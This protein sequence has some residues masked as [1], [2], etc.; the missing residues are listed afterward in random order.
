MFLKKKSTYKRDGGKK[1]TIEMNFF[2]CNVKRGRNSTL[3]FFLVARFLGLLMVV[4][5]N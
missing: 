5:N 3:V 4:L 1:R 2:M